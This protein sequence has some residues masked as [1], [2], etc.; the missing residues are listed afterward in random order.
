MSDALT[1]V[2][3]ELHSIRPRRLHSERASLAYL[4]LIA[5]STTV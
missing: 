4:D 1:A 3:L 2:T 5:N